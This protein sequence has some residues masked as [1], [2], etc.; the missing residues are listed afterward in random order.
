M[1]FKRNK[2]K[3]TYTMNAE[4]FNIFKSYCEENCIN[5]S[6]LIEKLIIKEL[7]SKGVKFK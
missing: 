3:K 5:M 2:A 7:K 4:N 1:D 6:N